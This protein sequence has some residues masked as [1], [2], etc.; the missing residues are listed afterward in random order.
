MPFHT[1]MWPGSLIGADDGWNLPHQIASNEY[2]NYEGGQFSKSRGRGIFSDQVRELPFPADVWR[3]YLTANRPERKDV[4]FSW[5]G[6]RETVNTSI[7]NNLANLAY[8]LGNVKLI[9]DGQTETFVDNDEANQHLKPTYR[10]P[11]RI[12]DEV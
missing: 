2:L 10:D 7:I 4:D 6:L 3:F 1:I 12:P 9:F 11:Y 5:Q 8:R